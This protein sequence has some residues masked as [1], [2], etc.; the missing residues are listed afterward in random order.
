MAQTQTTRETRP[1]PPG[2]IT[3]AIDLPT[4]HDD[5]VRAFSLQGRFKAVRAGRRWGKTKFGEVVAADAA[6]RSQ[7]IGWFAPEYKFLAESYLDLAD[8]LQ[9]LRLNSQ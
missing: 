3:V 1:P 8:M 6:A 4:L 5:Q 2:S 7:L 9:P